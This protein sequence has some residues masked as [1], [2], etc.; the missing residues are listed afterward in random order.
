MRAKIISGN[1]SGFCAFADGFLRD[2]GNHLR[3]YSPL[4]VKNLKAYLKNTKE[5]RKLDYR[6]FGNQ[7]ILRID[8]GE[9]ILTQLEELAFKEK[10]VLAHVSALGAVNS[11]TAGVFNVSE[12]KFYANEFKG[13]FEIVSLTGT[14]SA[15]DSKP[16]IHLHMSAGDE[17]GAV[18]GGHLNKAV[19]SATCEMVITVIE[20][21]VDRKFNEEAGINLFEFYN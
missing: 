19:V 1:Q 4:P 13:D 17:K 10:L 20:G 16:Y 8:K 11:F 9:E 5:R 14:I 12:K 21:R 2:T 3:Q 7:I 18:Y 6:R 15:M